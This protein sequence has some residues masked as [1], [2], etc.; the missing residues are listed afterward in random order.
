MSDNGPF[1]AFVVKCG[2]CDQ[3]VKM[4]VLRT[5]SGHYIEDGCYTLEHQEGSHK[6]QPTHPHPKP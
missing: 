3:S 4:P 5:A 2:Q 6:L 1:A